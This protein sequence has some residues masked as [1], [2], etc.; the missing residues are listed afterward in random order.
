M[1]MRSLGSKQSK[2]NL[3]AIAGN[4]AALG[5][6]LA[7]STSTTAMA[8]D[9]IG[10]TLI[11][12]DVMV[13]T[14]P[15]DLQATNDL[16]AIGG[17]RLRAIGGTRLRAIGGTRLRAIGGTYLRAIGGTRLRTVEDSGQLQAIG[18]TRLRSIDDAELLAIGGTRLRAIGGTRLR[19]DDGDAELLAIGGTRLRAIGGTRLR[20]ESADSET[21]AIGGTRLRAADDMSSVQ[22][23]G[24][25]RLR[26]VDES[27]NLNAI[28]GTRLRSIDES[29]SIQAI[30]GT[31]LRAIGGTRLRAIGGTRL[32]TADVAS[33]AASGNLSDITSGPVL[34]GEDT[35]YDIY[36][37]GPV[38]A[39][40]IDS[41][42]ISVLNQ[43]IDVSSAEGVDSIHDIQIGTMALIVG[44]SSTGEGIIQISDEWFVPGSSVVAILGTVA[45]ESASTGQLKLTNGVV[46]DYNV[47]LSQNRG[48]LPAIGDVIFA[49]GVAY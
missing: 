16:N 35:G 18:G 30:G 44:N 26:A 47:T 43:S 33:E 3:Q 12:A 11:A 27:A 34:I 23:I 37:F 40:S 7:L 21:V 38:T 14:S 39:V 9:S 31:R 36:V 13:V 25:T 48:A 15:S 19:S 20:A 6:L 24:G 42:E 1:F 5:A 49:S 32:R 2:G 17:T 10:E 22:A 46:V 8:N 4:F 45:S 41:Y 29:N 28:G